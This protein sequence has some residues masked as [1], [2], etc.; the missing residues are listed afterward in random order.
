MGCGEEWAHP[1]L[2]QCAFYV[3]R[4]AGSRAVSPGLALFSGVGRFIYATIRA[5]V[6]RKDTKITEHIGIRIIQAEYVRAHF[7]N[8]PQLRLREIQL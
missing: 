7:G 3:T 2:S 1:S 8:S 5:D 4:R 6:F